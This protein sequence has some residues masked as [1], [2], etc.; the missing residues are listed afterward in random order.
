M[1]KAGSPVGPMCLAHKNIY[2]F[3]SFVFLFIVLLLIYFHTLDKQTQ[4]LMLHYERNDCLHLLK[5]QLF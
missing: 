2:N 1:V 3:P 5:K 4:S